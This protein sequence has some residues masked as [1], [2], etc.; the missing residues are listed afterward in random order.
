[1]NPVVA[2]RYFINM[3]TESDFCEHKLL[4]YML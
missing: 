2:I 4:V 1:M 3:L